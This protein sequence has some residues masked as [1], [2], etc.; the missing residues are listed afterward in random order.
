LV[1]VST[2]ILEKVKSIRRKYTTYL[3]GPDGP[4]VQADG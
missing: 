4:G 3:K 2:A 1:C